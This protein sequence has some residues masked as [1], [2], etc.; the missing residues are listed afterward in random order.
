MKR[1]YTMFDLCKADVKDK[2]SLAIFKAKLLK[3]QEIFTYK[4]KDVHS[5]FNQYQEMIWN[6]TVYRTFDEAR[7]LSEIT[8]SVTTGFPGTLVELI[9]ANF[10]F[11]QSMAIRRLTDPHEWRP[12]R[13]VYSLPSIIK[14]IIS[15]KE[16]FTREN[17]ICYKGKPFDSLSLDNRDKIV[18]EIRNKKFDRITMENAT[19]S[20]DDRINVNILK[21][22][23]KKLKSF[24]LV[25]S[26]T[27]KYIAHAAAPE[28]RKKI[29][30]ELKNLSLQELEDSYKRLAKIG[31]V[32]GDILDSNFLAELAATQIDQLENWDKPLVTKGD[33]LKLYDYW[34]G[35]EKMFK[36]W[37]RN[38]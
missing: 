11:S 1:N 32:I 10:F 18:H 36:E 34:E 27:N 31:K 2:E 22:I 38:E 3:L 30:P 26:F 28:N 8:N 23:E 21:E 14:E 17:Y 4:T 16:I 15:I 37:E 35:R 24:E 12:E 9:D 25:R 6:D 20:R 13:A 7:R 19:R 29:D 33:K 5:I